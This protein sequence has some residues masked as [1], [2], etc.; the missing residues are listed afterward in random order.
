MRFVYVVILSLLCSLAHA[1]VVYRW[2]DDAGKVQYSDK[3]PVGQAKSLKE[4]DKSG[5]VRK[6]N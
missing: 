5:R 4:L 6:G 3:P 2:V 1:A